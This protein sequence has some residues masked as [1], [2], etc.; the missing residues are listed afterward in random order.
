M[1]YNI[2]HMHVYRLVLI[3]AHLSPLR[4]PGLCSIPVW[5]GESGTDH[6]TTAPA[7]AEG[8]AELSLRVT[9]CKGRF[10]V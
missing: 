5:Y 2:C 8:Y 6:A 3:D 10:H 1:S 4:S 7:T 9:M